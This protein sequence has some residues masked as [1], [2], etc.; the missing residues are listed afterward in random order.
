MIL[1]TI[2]NVGLAIGVLVIVVTPLV[3]V[4]LTQRRDR[5]RPVA[6]EAPA[7]QPQ[8]PQPSEPSGRGSQPVYKPVIGRM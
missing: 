3:W 8:G 5:P 2:L 7:V 1:T 4:I 6:A